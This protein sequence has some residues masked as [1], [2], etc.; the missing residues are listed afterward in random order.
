VNGSQF[1]VHI[2]ND[3]SKPLVINK[4]DHVGLV[5]ENCECDVTAGKKGVD[6]M[7]NKVMG[8]EEISSEGDESDESRSVE[9]DPV[10]A[11]DLQW[12]YEKHTLGMVD[13]I[14]SEPSEP[15]SDYRLW[16]ESEE[17]SEPDITEQ[18]WNNVIWKNSA[19]N[20]NNVT[21]VEDDPLFENPA[22]VA[23]IKEVWGKLGIQFKD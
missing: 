9:G 13:D 7:K 8:V 6:V 16:S 5:D 19:N 20:V 15:E 18:Q 14:Q 12:I 1:H 22:V 10:G 17:E 2:A 3:S 21:K 23:H 11:E 4:E